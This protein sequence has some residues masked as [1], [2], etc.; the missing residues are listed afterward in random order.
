MNNK[1][2][3]DSP[4]P[5]PEPDPE[6]LVRN[7]KVFTEKSIDLAAAMNRRNL[8]P[9]TEQEGDSNT[10]EMVRT[11][12]KVAELWARDPGDFFKAQGDLLE[13]Q[14]RLWSGATRRALGDDVDPIVKPGD[15]DRRFADADWQHNPFFDTLKQ[16]YLLTANWAQDLVE[17]TEGLDPHTQH[18]A[19]FF[20]RQITDALAPTNFPLTNPE[21]LRETLATSGRNLVEGMAANWPFA[22]PTWKPSPLAKIW[23]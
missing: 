6:E 22:I 1:S 19:A 2:H 9:A 18:K 7:L 12:G 11:F 4:E 10:S 20:V 5:L 16:T 17:R 3:T 15:N 21:V 13:A 8:A 23:R 14:M